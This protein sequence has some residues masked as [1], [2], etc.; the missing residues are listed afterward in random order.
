MYYHWKLSY[1][2]DKNLE[3]ICLFIFTRCNLSK[4]DKKRNEKITYPSWYYVTLIPMRKSAVKR[5]A[6]TTDI[7]WHLITEFMVSPAEYDASVWILSWLFQIKT[8]HWKHSFPTNPEILGSER[9]AVPTHSPVE[10]S[11]WPL[12]PL[13]NW[14]KLWWSDIQYDQGLLTLWYMGESRFNC[15]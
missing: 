3:L 7:Y 2:G 14:K 4:T 12:F 9:Q 10:A 5:I 15:N 6:N 8:S 13:R 11:H 1:Q